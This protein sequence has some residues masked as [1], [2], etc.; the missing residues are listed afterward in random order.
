MCEY[1]LSLRGVTS[2]TSDKERGAPR[3]MMAGSTS[4]RG[5]SAEL[6]YKCLLETGGGEWAGVDGVVGSKELA[7]EE[8]SVPVS[9][10][11][12]ERMANAASA[13]RGVV[14]RE[15]PVLPKGVVTTW[16][17]GCRR[18]STVKSEVMLQDRDRVAAL[19][20]AA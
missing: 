17:S 7:V 4:V 3:V 11:E 1:R 15:D 16:Q 10:R 12:G 2:G 5:R 18:M 20:Q 19:D 8:C 13:S 14:P 9:E 6:Q